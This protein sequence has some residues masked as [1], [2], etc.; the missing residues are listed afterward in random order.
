ME[1]PTYV[2]LLFIFIKRTNGN[3]W[4]VSLTLHEKLTA[5][6]AKLTLASS[7]TSLSVVQIAPMIHYDGHR[8]MCGSKLNVV[9]W[10]S[11]G[12]YR[13]MF[14]HCDRVSLPSHLVISLFIFSHYTFHSLLVK[15]FIK[16]RFSA[17][18]LKQI[19]PSQL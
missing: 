6:R 3:V 5:F 2:Q 4:T 9:I 17:S 19:C 10:A 8:Q 16:E 11:F 7:N 18:K 12:V 15:Q 13:V 14:I 1:N